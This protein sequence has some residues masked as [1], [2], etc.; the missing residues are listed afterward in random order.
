MS[1]GPKSAVCEWQARL[2]SR[3]GGQVET[4]NPIL[5]SKSGELKQ[6]LQ[7]K[8]LLGRA[9]KLHGAA[10]PG[11][12]LALAFPSQFHLAG[13][14]A[15]GETD[16]GLIDLVPTLFRRDN[17]ESN[18]LARDL[19]LGNR[20]ALIVPVQFSAERCAILRKSEGDIL[21]RPVS[22]RDLSHPD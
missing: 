10:I 16:P 12:G 6:P 22:A 1:R 19:T 2:P 8:S 9:L 13:F 11:I 15:P 17:D 18:L 3:Q 7:P 21:R 14:D 5:K 20:R 4:A